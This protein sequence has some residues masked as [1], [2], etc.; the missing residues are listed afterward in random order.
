M[1]VSGMALTQHLAMHGDLVWPFFV[2]F[3][4][5]HPSGKFKV[6]EPTDRPLICLGGGGGGEGVIVSRPTRDIADL[7][8]DPANCLPTQLVSWNDPCTCD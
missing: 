5:D 8:A 6:C 3:N 2:S 7:V 4:D 1:T